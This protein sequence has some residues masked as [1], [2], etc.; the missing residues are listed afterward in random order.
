MCISP[1]KQCEVYIRFIKGLVTITLPQK[2][3]RKK[4]KTNLKHIS[5]V[6]NRFQI[7]E[8]IQS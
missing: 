2:K 3:K 1:G 8:I 4:K 7:E 6:R 5:M